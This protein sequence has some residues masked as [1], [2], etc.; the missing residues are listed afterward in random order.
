MILPVPC[1]GCCRLTTAVGGSCDD[2]CLEAL[3]WMGTVHLR[4]R[5]SAA[6]VLPAAQAELAKT[7]A[8]LR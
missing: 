8:L 3:D 4:S 5:F 2:L 7:S 6:D 1:H